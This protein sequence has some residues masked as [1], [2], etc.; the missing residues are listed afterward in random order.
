MHLSI[1]G[2]YTQLRWDSLLA[3][4]LCTCCTDCW[5]V[6]KCKHKQCKEVGVTVITRYFHVPLA[7]TLLQSSFAYEVSNHEIWH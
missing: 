1:T 6:N 2:V 5:E 3:E 7:K 4:F